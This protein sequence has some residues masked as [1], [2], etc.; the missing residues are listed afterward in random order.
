[1]GLCAPFENRWGILL[2]NFSREHKTITE[3]KIL[4]SVT[5]VTIVICIFIFL[6]S[7]IMP[8]VG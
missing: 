4:H 6:T 3:A 7:G 5:I 2:G 8:T 1:M